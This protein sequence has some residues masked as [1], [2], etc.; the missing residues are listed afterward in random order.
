MFSESKFTGAG[1]ITLNVI[2]VL[3][4]I[5]LLLVVVASWIMLVMTVKTSSFFF[6]DGVSHFI[7]SSIGLFLVV[8]EVTLFRSYFARHWPMLS[9]D[10]G[11]VFLGLAMIVLGFN[12][13][14]NLNKAATSVENLGLPMWR[15]VISSGVLTAVMGFFNIIATYVFCDSKLSITGRQVRS[16]GASVPKEP[17]THTK[18]FSLSSTSSRRSTSESLPSYNAPPP[19]SSDRQKSRFSFRLPVRSSKLPFAISKPYMHDPEQFAKWDESRSSPVAPGLAVQ[20]PPTALHPYHQGTVNPPPP[21]PSSR[22]S[23]VSN[24]TRF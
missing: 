12:I 4:I 6:F 21:P 20:R 3:N 13:L 1:Y 16:H 24:M 10:S 15:I 9:P 5:S 7:T 2:R 8:S 19:A 23:V 14:G 18:T 22:Y 11:F 17:S